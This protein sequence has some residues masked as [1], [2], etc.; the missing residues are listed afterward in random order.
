MVSTCRLEDIDASTIGLG[1]IIQLARATDTVDLHFADA[2][3]KQESDVE[4]L[5]SYGIDLLIISPS[6]VEALTPVISRA[7]EKIPVIVLDRA[8]EGYDYSLFIGPDNDLIGRQAGKTVLELLAEDGVFG[9]SVLEM[10]NNSLASES[11]SAEL[12]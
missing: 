7:Y 10:K 6:D 5:M 3:Q 1:K 2:Q 11:R 12:M 9:A 4:R 8:M